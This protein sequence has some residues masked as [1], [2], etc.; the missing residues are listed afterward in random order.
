MLLDCRLNLAL[1]VNTPQF[2]VPQSVQNFWSDFRAVPQLM[3]NRS[4]VCA[5]GFGIP[6]LGQNL[7][8]T[9]S[10]AWQL[11]HCASRARLRKSRF[12]V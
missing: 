3:Q 11:G 7:W 2:F 12:L 8:P 1:T 9:P 6:Q 5:A 4:C 10:L